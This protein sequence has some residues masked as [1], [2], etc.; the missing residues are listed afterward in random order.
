MERDGQQVFEIPYHLSL[1][2]PLKPLGKDVIPS[3]I[4]FDFRSNERKANDLL[5]KAPR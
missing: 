5:G 4:L 1:H 3:R 2:A